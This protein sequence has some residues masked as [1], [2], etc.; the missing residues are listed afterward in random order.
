MLQTSQENTGNGGSVDWSPVSNSIGGEELLHLVTLL[1]SYVLG[2]HSHRSPK[3][4]SRD[5]VDRMAMVTDALERPRKRRRIRM[6]DEPPIPALS[7]PEVAFMASQ[8][9]TSTDNP[10]NLD[11]DICVSHDI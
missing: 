9:G 6:T 4:R 11:N 7:L 8:D 2:A 5:S 1:S 10:N 3:S